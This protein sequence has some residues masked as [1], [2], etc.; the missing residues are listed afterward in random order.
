MCIRDSFT[1]GSAIADDW[2]FVSIPDLFNAD[3]ADLSGGADPSIAA[4]FS[5]NYANQLI[6][7]PNW[8]PSGPNSMNAEFAAVLHQMMND[9]AASTENNPE[10]ALIAGDLIGGRWP[11]NRDSL[12]ILFGNSNTTLA[13]ELDAASASYYTW[14]RTLFAESGITTCLL[15]TSPSP[16]D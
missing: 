1:A 8:T 15:Y 2:S 6:A 14:I 10:L 12:K 13:Q 3:Y 5:N 16:R 11:Q 9:I 7:A 4:V